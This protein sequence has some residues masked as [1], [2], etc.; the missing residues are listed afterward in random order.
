MSDAFKDW[1]TDGKGHLKV[2]PLYGF[3][4]ALFGE[5]AAGLRVEIG[6]S[7]PK[8]GEP[9]PALQLVLRPEQVRELAEALTELADLL[10]VPAKRTGRA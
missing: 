4:T 5:D 7:A 9:I 3:T 2:W 1:E 8:A 6:T 10:K